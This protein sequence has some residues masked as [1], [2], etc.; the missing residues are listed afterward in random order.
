MRNLLRA[1]FMPMHALS[2]WSAKLWWIAQSRSWAS[3]NCA[4]RQKSVARSGGPPALEK[5]VYVI[6]SNFLW[7]AR[8]AFLLA[9]LLTFREAR[10]LRLEGSG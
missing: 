9:F 4:G 5:S 10:M 1:E 3:L 2:P 8:L 7:C 6:D